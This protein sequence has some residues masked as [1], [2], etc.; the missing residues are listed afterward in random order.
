MGF[1]NA[2]ETDPKRKFRWYLQF[3]SPNGTGDSPLQLAAKKIDKPKFEISTTPHKFINHT[4]FFPG[5]L[6][7]K[8]I[9]A[10][11]VD[12]GGPDSDIAKILF[13]K[14]AGKDGSGYMIPVLPKDCRKSITKNQSV[15]AFGSNF[16]IV[17]TDGAGAPVEQWSLQN[18]WISTIEFGDLDYTSE[19]LIEITMTIVY[20]AARKL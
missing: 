17:Q 6:E 1:W 19:D 10:T 9:T 5:R 16:T 13:E 4:F 18:P 20:D 3:G 7:W 14:I 15:N 12:I 2:Q 8:P 11:F